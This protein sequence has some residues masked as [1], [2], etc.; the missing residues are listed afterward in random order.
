MVFL[1]C[2]FVDILLYLWFN[3]Y[4]LLNEI[5][6]INVVCYLKICES[7]Y[8]QKNHKQNLS[9]NVWFFLIIYTRKCYI[10]DSLF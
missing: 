3:L 8:T 6:F 5:L 9:G 1:W 2:I 7:I 4:S 10:A